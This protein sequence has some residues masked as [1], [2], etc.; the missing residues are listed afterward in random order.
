VKEEQWERAKELLW[1]TLALPPQDRDQYLQATCG[2]D[3]ELRL[4]VQEL[5]TRADTPIGTLGCF[6]SLTGTTL[7]HYQVLE[8]IGEGA[9]GAVYRAHD[10]HLERVVALKVLP[11]P[12]RCNPESVRRFRL[13]GR[14]LSALTHP[15]IV[16]VFS[17]EE[18]DGRIFLV[19]EHVT[20]RALAGCIRGEAIDFDLALKYAVQI[21]RALAAAHGRGI[22]HRDLKPSNILVT[23]EHVAKV[24]DFGL[25]KILQPTHVPGE[26]ERTRPG[27]LLGTTDYMSPEHVRAG[28]VDQRSDIFSF[29]SILFEMLTGTRPFNREYSV[30]TMAAIANEP[31]APSPRPLPEQWQAILQRCHA[32][33]PAD[34]FQCGDELAAALEALIFHPPP[35]RRHGILA[36]AVVIVLGLGIWG[37]SHFLSDATAAAQQ[38]LTP[39]DRFNRALEG[40]N[41]AEATGCI[42]NRPGSCDIKTAIS[43]LRAAETDWNVLFQSYPHH[44]SSLWNAALAEQGLCALYSRAKEWNA[45]TAACERAIGHFTESLGSGKAYTEL[46]NSSPDEADVLWNRALTHR[47]RAHEPDLARDAKTGEL[48]RGIADLD[49]ILAGQSRYAAFLK[50]RRSEVVQTRSEMQRERAT[51]ATHAGH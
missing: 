36:A 3:H 35:P 4:C 45:A 40:Q 5:L 1:Q 9:T 28:V 44:P 12:L 18:C 27:T 19:M 24:V 43:Y 46:P 47:L 37:G 23:N 11:M 31:A 17:L 38:S 26:D 39:S 15:N 22:I 7:G 51:A 34:R 42:G 41:K 14:C 21:A 33:A 2:A 30:E 49:R 20:G 25:A 48:S 29:G 8:K 16:Q 6:E 32:K 13:E 10:T 50:E